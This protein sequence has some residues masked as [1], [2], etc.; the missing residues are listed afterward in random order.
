M[1]VFVVGHDV[2]SLSICCPLCSKYQ[3]WKRTV[4]FG[5]DTYWPK[6]LCTSNIILS[7][8]CFWF[9]LVGFKHFR[10]L[11]SHFPTIKFGTISRIYY[12]YLNPVSTNVHFN[13]VYQSHCFI[14]KGRHVKIVEDSTDSSPTSSDHSEWKRVK[15]VEGIVLESWWPLCCGDKNLQMHVRQKNRPVG[16]V[17]WTP[18]EDWSGHLESQ[19]WQSTLCVAWCLMC[20]ASCELKE[21]DVIIWHLMSLLRPGAI[22]TYTARPRLLAS[23]DLLTVTVA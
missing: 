1:K 22:N 8:S 5:T 19:G 7:S 10:E 3:G 23:V 17:K 18:E 6:P 20:V 21:S 2:S 12:R 16:E 4:M 9:Q 15:E 14:L 13:T 11:L